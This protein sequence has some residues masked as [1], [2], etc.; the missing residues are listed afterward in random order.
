MEAV[1]RRREETRTK[2]LTKCATTEK[3]RGLRRKNQRDLH[4]QT[5]RALRTTTTHTVNLDPYNS[6][7]HIR[8]QKRQYDPSARSRHTSREICKAS[9]GKND[10]DQCHDAYFEHSTVLSDLGPDG[11]HCHKARTTGYRIRIIERSLGHEEVLYEVS[12]GL[13]QDS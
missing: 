12:K 2:V 1:W 9:Q 3:C 13:R 8:S 10:D 5:E 4:T 7:G 11:S 6:T